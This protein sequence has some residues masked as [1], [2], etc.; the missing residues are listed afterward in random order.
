MIEDIAIPATLYLC[1]RCLFEW[2]SFSSQPSQFCRNLECRSREWHG[3]KQ[4][5]QSHTNE[6]K[7]PAPRTRGRPKTCTIFDYSEDP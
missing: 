3:K 4:H 5:V 7:F 6:I 2:L 1:E